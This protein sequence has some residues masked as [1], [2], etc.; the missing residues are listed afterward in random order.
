MRDRCHRWL[1]PSLFALIGLCFLLPFATVSCDNATTTFTGIELVTHTVPSGGYVNRVDCSADISV[2]VERN[3]ATTA[4]IALAAAL[5]GLVLGVLGV[6][7]G[8]G[9]CA[10][11]GFGALVA[12][13][14]R[15]PLGPDVS[16]H[17]GYWLALLLSSSVGLL[18]LRRAWRRRRRYATTQPKPRRPLA[19]HR[20]ALLVYALAAFAA[21]AL[22]DSPYRAVQAISSFALVWLTF[23]VGP[24]WLVVAGMLFRW[25]KQHREAL[26]ERTARWDRLLWLGPFLALPLCSRKLRPSLLPS[27]N[28]QPSAENLLSSSEDEAAWA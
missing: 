22:T 4:T 25:Q 1:S 21:G 28:E 17:S 5:L 14:F 20:Q 24:A 12:L 3:G 13:E 10:A 9:W 11:V 19:A 27:R 26:L 7:R 6:A 23:V 8:P 15:A 2:C 18:H 16:L